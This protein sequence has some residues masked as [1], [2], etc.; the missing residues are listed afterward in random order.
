MAV[1]RFIQTETVVLNIPFQFIQLLQRTG[2]INSFKFTLPDFRVSH[3]EGSDKH[4]VEKGMEIN[5][6][7]LL[8]FDF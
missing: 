4:S 3:F 2:Q 1:E 6:I 5:K 7:L 8:S